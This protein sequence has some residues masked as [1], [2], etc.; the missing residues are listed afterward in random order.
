MRY[1]PLLP[2][3]ETCSLV[4]SCEELG[5]YNYNLKLKATAAGTERAL[6]FKSSLGATQEQTFKFRSFVPEGGTYSCSVGNKDFF[7]VAEETVTAPPSADWEGV[8]VSVKVFFEPNQMGD[9]KDTLRI[10][11]ATGGD[12][13]CILQGQCTQ[14][15]PRGPFTIAKGQTQ[16]IPF[17]N[18]FS[19]SREFTF[20]V[21]NPEF[22]VAGEKATINGKAEFIAKVTFKGENAKPAGVSGKLL[23]SCPGIP[24]WV[25]Y[26]KGDMQS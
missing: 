4:I 13:S 15:L 26:L 18:V 16:D 19:D 23:V 21:D 8:E 9:V 10:T 17:K 11:S 20:T 3:E 22:A 5:D 6:N 7:R 1:R 24:P 25:F 2:S 14:P 12:Y